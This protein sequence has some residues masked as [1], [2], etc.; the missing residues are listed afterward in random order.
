MEYIINIDDIKNYNIIFRHPIKN[1]NERFTNFYKIIYSDALI[2][3]KYI[4]LAFNLKQYDVIK[5]NS[6]YLLYIEKN[7]EIFTKIKNIE[8]MILDSINMNIKKNIVFNCYNE[9]ISKP[10]LYCFQ[11]MPKLMHFSLKISGVWE[12]KSNIGL[13]YKLYYNTSTEKLLSMTC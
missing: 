13:V 11:H 3:L 6:N 8:K 4:L 5:N 10:F 9:L 7:E 2:T 1:Q 12:D